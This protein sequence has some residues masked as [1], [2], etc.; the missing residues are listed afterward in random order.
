MGNAMLA[1]LRAAMVMSS[2]RLNDMLARHAP[3]LCPFVMLAEFPRSGVNW[4]RDLLADC[5]QLPV[6]RHAMFPV[7]FPAILQTHS[8]TPIRGIPVA[9]VLRDGRDVFVSH[10]WHCVSAVE[11][12]GALARRVLRFHPSLGDAASP[13][14]ARMT[15]FYDE[16]RRR[17]SGSR[18]NWGEHVRNW[19]TPEAGRAPAVIRFE[20]LRSDPHATLRRAIGDLGMPVPENFVIDFAVERNALHRQVSRSTGPVDNLTRL[21]RKAS[22]GGWRGEMPEALQRRFRDD[23]GAA[24]ALAGYPEV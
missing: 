13:V 16:W 6:P 15:R 8:A 10:F 21:R 9:Y 4:T 1:R 12:D 23:F 3:G 18:A 7:T 20:A 2:A 19:L 22:V 17:P 24:L 11:G 5:L 14:E